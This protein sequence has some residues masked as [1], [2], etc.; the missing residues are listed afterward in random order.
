MLF[1]DYSGGN[2]SEGELVGV[3]EGNEIHFS[4]T[5]RLGDGKAL[6]GTGHHTLVSGEDGAV[7]LVF[8]QELT[9]GRRGITVMEEAREVLTEFRDMAEADIKAV[10]KL[11]GEMAKEIGFETQDAFMELDDATTE[12]DFAAELQLALSRSDRKIIVVSEGGNIRGF[13][14]GR[15]TDNFISFS[16]I[17]KIGRIM[18]AYVQPEFRKQGFLKRMEKKIS[19]FFKA[20]GVLYSD[21]NNL[22]ANRKARDAWTALEYSTYREQMRKKL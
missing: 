19:D 6:S 10:S 12:E 13:L 18:S 22:S 17:K 9:G 4:F 7:R 20:K 2:I 8:E 1:A 5:H 16:K 11:A 21:L 15:I 14:E 3:L